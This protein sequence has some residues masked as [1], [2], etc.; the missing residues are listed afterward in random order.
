MHIIER[1]YLTMSSKT[2]Q[3]DER[4]NAITKGQFDNGLMK[5]KGLRARKELAFLMMPPF[6]CVSLVVVSAYIS[7]KGW[8]IKFLSRWSWCLLYPSFHLLTALLLL[9]YYFSSQQSKSRADGRFYGV[10]QWELCC[11]FRFICSDER[12]CM[13][14][15]Y[16]LAGVWRLL[17]F[18][19][20]HRKMKALTA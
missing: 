6:E 2:N 14:R 10:L 1:R 20:R 5:G 9:D 13:T 19:T 7:G 3:D 8:S 16:Y 11:C 15:Q 12:L 17:R 18:K 4:V